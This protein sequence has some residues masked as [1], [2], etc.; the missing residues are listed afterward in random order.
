[1]G[2][3][4]QLER[5]RP[6]YPGQIGVP[7]SDALTGIRT[8]SGGV[9][10]VGDSTATHY[11][12]NDNN[13]GTD[14]MAPKATITGALAACTNDYSD[15]IVLLSNNNV[16]TG[17][18]TIA[19]SRVQLVAWDYWRGESAPS[20]S[21][22]SALANF[23]LLA[24]EAD[25]VEIAGIRF[26]NGTDAANDCIAVGATAA[27][28]GCYIHDCKFA[29]GGGY[30]VN[31]GSALGTV[32]DITVRNNTFIQINNNA[33]AA[34][35]RLGY[36]VRAD[37][38]DNLF[39]TDQAGT[40]GVSCRNASSGGSVIRNNDFFIEEVNGVA[41]F[42]AGA[43]VDALMVDN[44]VGGGPTNITAITRTNDGGL[45]ASQ[46]YCTSGAGGLIIDAT[47]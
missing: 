27:V 15:T 37:I 12:A 30:G 46:N 29:V 5:L 23:T 42:R 41:I 45:Y 4:W 9:F 2:R 3:E 38:D 1:M 35:V 39:L 20:V 16:L 47:L 10:Y 13:D 18:N 19:V 32:N 17:T 33:G 11:Y 26:A 22:T 36:A 8:G 25:Q 31:I 34:G 21:I 14:P 43:T 6:F 7:G 28:V 40:Y 24:V 44:R